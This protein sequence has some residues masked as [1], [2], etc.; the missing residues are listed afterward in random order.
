MSPRKF[1]VLFLLGLLGVGL[2]SIVLPE[3]HRGPGFS[4][5]DGDE[6]DAALTSPKSGAVYFQQGISTVTSLPT[7]PRPAVHRLRLAPRPIPAPTSAPPL[8]HLTRAP[9]VR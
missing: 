3:D 2:G 8:L 6:D 1:L 5:Y 7:L 4:P 9:P